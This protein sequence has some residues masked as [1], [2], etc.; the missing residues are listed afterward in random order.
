MALTRKILRLVLKLHAM[1]GETN[2]NVAE[3][4]RKKLLK[5]LTEQGF[6]WNDL[7]AVLRKA[8]EAERK[9]KASTSAPADA[10]PPPPATPPPPLVN[11]LDLVMRLIEQY[12]GVTPEQCLA[13]ALWILYTHIFFRDLF[14]ISPRLLLTSPV[15]GCGKT[16]MLIL[17]EAL[18]ANAERSD[19]V[20]AASI[21][22]DLDPWKPTPTLL[23]DEGD[24]LG[25]L[26]DRVLRAVLNSGHRKG[27]VFKRYS[28][29]RVRKFEVFAPLALAAIY[30]D[31]GLLPRPLLQ[32]CI[33][34]VMHRPTPDEQKLLER[35]DENSPQF[36]AVRDAAQKELHAWAANCELNRDPEVPLRLRGA[37]NWRPLL[38]IAD[39]LGHLTARSRKKTR[40]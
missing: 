3:V 37:D 13:I 29:K 7:T 9:G 19:N 8:E 23:L 6:T 32:R 17:L 25:L 12:L 35:L 22:Y 36:L 27:G 10:P 40:S 20:T 2:A 26:T 33:W 31:Y 16:T 4:A 28:G 18:T 34:I 1:L 21:Y 15:R 5:L 39:D 38:A 30:D 24:N 11:V 14:N